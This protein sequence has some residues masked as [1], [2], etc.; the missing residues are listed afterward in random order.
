LLIFHWDASVVRCI[1]RVLL[2]RRIP[3]R[4]IYV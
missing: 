4:G 2:H 3:W 1:R